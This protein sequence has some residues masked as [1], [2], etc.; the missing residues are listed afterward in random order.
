MRHVPVIEPRGLW[1]GRYARLE[2]DSARVIDRFNQLASQLPCRD[3]T[4]LFIASHYERAEMTA[5][6]VLSRLGINPNKGILID[7]GFAEQNYGDMADKHHHDIQHES[8]VRDYMSDM[9]N[10]AP[11]GGESMA[12][13]QARIAGALDIAISR[14][15]EHID[16]VVIF[17]HGGTQIAALAHAK[18][19]TIMDVW[20]RRK[21]DPG[22]DF[23]YM[24]TLGLAYDRE[25]AKWSK[26]YT[27]DPGIGKPLNPS[28]RSRDLSPS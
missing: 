15:S 2:M 12:M 25:S 3:D 19:L 22:L 9:W 21:Q 13:F 17:C 23:S 5:N 14:L 7:A 4:T 6:G 26:N 20:E 8:A 11:P 28:G 24:S 1:Y 10:N 27:L 16:N 18:G